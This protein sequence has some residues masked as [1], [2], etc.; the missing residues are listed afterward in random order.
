MSIANLLVPNNYNI[1]IGD[2]IVGDDLT[3]NGNLLVSGF[4]TFQGIQYTNSQGSGLTLTEL[5]AINSSTLTNMT[6]AAPLTAA[7]VVN[8]VVSLALA[9]AGAVTLPTLA[10]LN[11]YIMAFTGVPVPDGLT[12]TCSFSSPTASANAT[13]TSS[14]DVVIH[15]GAGGPPT[16]LTIAANTTRILTFRYNLAGV[17]YVAY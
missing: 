2:L 8:G 4:S 15:S 11:A 3:V 17:Q 10:Q 6:I 16:T 13:L 12:F 14:A 1:Q 5:F 7:Q 9:I